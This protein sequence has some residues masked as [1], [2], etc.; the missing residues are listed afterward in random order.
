MAQPYKFAI[1]RLAPD[2]A[3]GECLNV[4]VVVMTDGGLDIRLGKRL[5]KVR[6]ISGAID[7]SLLQALLT[8]L[9]RLDQQAREAGNKTLRAQLLQ[10][11]GPLKLSKEGAF[12]AK[13]A[14]EYEARVASLMKAMVEPEPAAHR[15]R[16]KRSRLLTQVKKSF[17]QQHV[18]AKAGEDLSSHRIITGF[19]V[20]E[21][22]VADFVLKNGKMHVVETVDA[23]GDDMS[24][25]RAIADIG[26]AAL[27]L[28]RARMTYGE[29]GT[30]ARLVYSASD[31]LE[32]IA[33]PS[34]DA[35]EHQGAKLINWA[36]AQDRQ[37]FVHDLAELATPLPTKQR[38]TVRFASPAGGLF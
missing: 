27:V 8:D 3:R 34:L 11:I 7:T 9:N 15:V 14:D 30:S 21:G 37:R 6:A 38:K 13:D 31:H 1:L 2:D 35:A 18:L 33:R 20:D 23:S 16:E 10:H 26:V 28:E 36:S 4:G 12:S 32:R 5:D 25:R 29:N 24:V 22:L 19:E 17:R